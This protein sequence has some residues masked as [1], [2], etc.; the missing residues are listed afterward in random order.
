MR[1]YRNYIFDIVI[2]ALA[3]VLG[4]VM[5]PPFGI[6]Q[7]VLNLLLAVSL[8]AYLAIHLFGKLQRTKGA[9]FILTLV[10][11]SVVC[12][13]IIGLVFQQLRVFNI[14]G[15]CRT[16]GVVLWLR[17]IVSI[18]VM[19]I[20]LG[21]LKSARYNLPKFALYLLLITAGVYLFAN[22][23]ITDYVFNWILCVIMLLT[24]VIFAFLTFI[25]APSKK[26]KG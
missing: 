18:T 20:N 2:C 12:I 19:Y 9:T 24:G 6:G 14:V 11:F 15:V 26:K 22:P 25:Y 16:L 17:G 3:T 23:L 1:T 4:I 13:I 5:L 7:Q 8:A 10:E 21:T